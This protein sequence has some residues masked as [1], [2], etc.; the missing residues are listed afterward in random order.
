MVFKNPF[1]IRHI[2]INKILVSAIRKPENTPF[3]LLDIDLE[4]FH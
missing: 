1:K 3:S 2:F 4:K